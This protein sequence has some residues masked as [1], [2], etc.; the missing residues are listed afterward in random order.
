MWIKI[1]WAIKK[2]NKFQRIK[3]TWSILSDHK[4]IKLKITNNGLSKKA[5][6]FIN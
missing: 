3:I 4:G 2:I 1:Y 5:Q 6:I